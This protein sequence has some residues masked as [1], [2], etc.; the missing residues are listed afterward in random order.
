MLKDH[1]KDIALKDKKTIKGMLSSPYARTNNPNETDY[2][3][4]LSTIK[5]PVVLKWRNTPIAKA[6]KEKNVAGKI[7]CLFPG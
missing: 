4:A 2:S 6:L 7:V 1:P 5:S 3:Y